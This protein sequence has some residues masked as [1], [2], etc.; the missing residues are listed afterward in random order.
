MSYFRCHHILYFCYTLYNLWLLASKKNIQKLF[1]LNFIYLFVLFD[2]IIKYY[3]ISSSVYI[4]HVFGHLF[5]IYIILRYFF[6][7]YYIKIKIN[8][9]FYFNL[10]CWSMCWICEFFNNI[11]KFTK[12]YAIFIDTFINFN[13]HKAFRIFTYDK[14]ML[15]I[16]HLK[17][18]HCLMN[19]FNYLK[20]F[21]VIL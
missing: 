7:M 13:N 16:K 19:M 8:R 20:Y 15:Q 2:W 14:S 18:P 21:H 17:K 4:L 6:Y 12:N 10:H 11:Y 1:L 3:T 9:H 5:W